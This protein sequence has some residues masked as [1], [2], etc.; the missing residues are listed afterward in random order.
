M[1]RVSNTEDYTVM[2]MMLNGRGNGGGSRYPFTAAQWQEL[3]QQALIYK[4]MASG[5]P[6]PADLILPMRRSVLLDIGAGAAASIF[7]HQQQPKIGWGCGFQMGYGRKVE[8]LE[9]GRCRRTDGKKWR[10]S[11]EAHPD[12]KYCERHMHRGKNRSRKPVE[13]LLAAAPAAGRNREEES[14]PS[15]YVPNLH[16]RTLHHPVF[17]YSF[18][19]RDEAIDQYNCSADRPDTRAGAERNR[20]GSG[21]WSF[22]PLGMSL[23]EPNNK[24]PMSFLKPVDDVCDNG[25]DQQKKQRQGQYCFVLGDDFKLQI[26]KDDDGGRGY[27]VEEIKEEESQKR[28]RCFFGNWPLKKKEPPQSQPPSS[29]IDLEED[30]S[31]SKTQLSI[32]TPRSH[33]SP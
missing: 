12:S 13:T 26:P 31:F 33:F 9:P 15:G 21:S 1:S 3:E 6:I 29:W 4:Y 24:P 2:M 19:M 25:E 10:C 23:S 28:L 16:P 22:T 7:P 5:H 8:D 17:P 20:D 27:G 18:G 11:K 14:S 30:H 32:S